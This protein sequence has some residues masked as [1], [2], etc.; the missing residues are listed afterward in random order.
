[1]PCS[2]PRLRE[3]QPPRP[4]RFTRLLALPLESALIS[5]T[6]WPPA[7]GEIPRVALTPLADAVRHAIGDMAEDIDVAALGRTMADAAL[8]ERLGARLWPLAAVVPLP[9]LPSAWHAAGLPP[10]TA[11]AILAACRALW[12]A[13]CG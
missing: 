7:D 11:P 10:E 2:R 1:M 4:L 13:R 6:D 3:I 12:R 5:A 9:A 8:V